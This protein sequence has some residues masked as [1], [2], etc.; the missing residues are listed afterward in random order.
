MKKEAIIFNF[1]C[2][3]SISI[4]FSQT[5]NDVSFFNYSAFPQ[6]NFAAQNGNT[7]INKFELNI[8]TPPIQIGKRVKLVNSFYYQNTQFNYSSAFG[9]RNTFPKTLHDIRYSP[10]LLIQLHKNW[11]VVAIPRVLLRTDFKHSLSGDDFF[12]SGVV[13]LAY[14]VKGNQ[15]FKIGIGVIPIDNDFSRNAIYPITLLLYNSK[16]IKI[17]ILYPRANFIYKYSSNFE[18]GLFSL[19]EGAISHVSP[20]NVDNQT[21]DYFRTF[22]WVIAP[23][24]SHRIYKKLFAHLKV[25]YTPLQKMELLDKNFEALKNQDYGLKSSLYIRAGISLR[26]DN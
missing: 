25:G 1:C 11:E 3:F 21:T 20:F 19:V 14:A 9:D 12:P 7:T 24:A 10:T 23:A 4:A 5:I 2:C 18:F 6:T 22:H 26:I 15:N 13:V 16:K 17:E 8:S